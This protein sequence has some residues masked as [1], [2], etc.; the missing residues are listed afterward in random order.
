MELK[1]LEQLIEC[2]LFASGDA[3]SVEKM[4][5]I[6]QQDKKTIRSVIHRMMDE[7]DE[8]RG[9]LIREIN[10]TYQLSTN[11]KHKEY[12]DRL[13]ESRQK[14]TL[15]QA[16]LEVLAIIAYNEPV[17]RAGIE[18]IRGVNSDSILS[19]LIEKNLVREAGR[20]DLPGKPTLFET[21]EEFLKSFGLR[22]IKDMPP[23][24]YEMMLSTVENM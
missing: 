1:E 3:L 15:S 10:D 18:Q 17:T 13:F 2:L 6:L 22:S 7:F 19:R 21:T 12:L 9:I 14:Q 24:D 23:L 20:A 11:P 4:S 8:N 5:E 16:S